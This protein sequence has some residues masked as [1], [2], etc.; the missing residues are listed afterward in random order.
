MQLLG[1]SQIGELF[2]RQPEE[3]PTASGFDA[4]LQHLAALERR[5]PIAALSHLD[6][7]VGIGEGQRPGQGGASPVR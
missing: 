6:D 2:R 7:L 1:R 5:K 4:H 3:D